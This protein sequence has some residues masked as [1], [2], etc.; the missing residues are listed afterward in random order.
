MQL[1]LDVKP[2][3]SRECPYCMA[4]LGDIRARCASCGAAYHPACLDELG[5][6]ATLGCPDSKPGSRATPSALRPEPE[7][8]QREPSQPEPVRPP[9][10]PEAPQPP[11]WL[12]L[13]AILGTALALSAGF[14]LFVEETPFGSDKFLE[15]VTIGPVLLIVAAIATPPVGPGILLAIVFLT[16]KTY[17][18]V[19][20][21]WRGD[22][23]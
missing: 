4:A 21:A 6:C 16:G 18:L 22:E 8:G 12:F 10:R 3:P 14:A 7:P 19:V 13:V 20:R 23:P 1:D 2:R 15:I 5:R 9:R 11:L 17:E